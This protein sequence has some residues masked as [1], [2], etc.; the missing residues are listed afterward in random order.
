VRN[1]GL[2]KQR[3]LKGKK[4][5]K[6]WRHE[7]SHLRSREGAPNVLLKYSLGVR[8][9]IHDEFENDAIHSFPFESAID[10]AP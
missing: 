1:A 8:N 5:K 4:R 6:K 10:F 7:N 2:D 3:I 9:F